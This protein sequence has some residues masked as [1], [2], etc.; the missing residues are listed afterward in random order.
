MLVSVSTR[1]STWSLKGESCGRGDIGPSEAQEAPWS[2]SFIQCRRFISFEFNLLN[3]SG[4]ITVDLH[5]TVFSS[6]KFCIFCIHARFSRGTAL[7]CSVSRSRANQ[8]QPPFVSRRFSSKKA[9]ICTWMNGLTTELAGAWP[10]VHVIRLG[11]VMSDYVRVA[12]YIHTEDSKTPNWWE[13]TR[14]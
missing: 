14:K 9:N 3:N 12:M 1:K 7:D 5:D 10:L 4:W 13:I 6:Q 11:R 2:I 8:Q